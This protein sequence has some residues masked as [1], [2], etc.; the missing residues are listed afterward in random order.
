MN[1]RSVKG[2]LALAVTLAMLVSVFSGFTF[3]DSVQV[4]PIQEAGFADGKDDVDRDAEVTII[5]RLDGETAFESVKSVSGS[6]AKSEEL[7]KKQKS[8]QEVIEAALG[9]KIDVTHNYTLLYNGF[10]FDGNIW[11]IDE[12]NKLSGVS[13]YASPVY[14]LPVLPNM[15]SSTEIISAPIAW[16]LGYTGEG[17]VVAILDTGIRA[18]HEAFSVI[19]ENITLTTSALQEIMTNYGSYMHAGSDVASLYKSGKIPFGWNY[20]SNNY[21]PAHTASDHGTHVAATAAGNN[22]DDFSGVAPDAQI[23]VMQVFS[24]SGGASF[25]TI[26]AALED[27]AYLGVDSANMSLG[28][29]AGFSAYYDP[30]YSDVFDLLDEAGVNLSVSAGNGNTTADNN[31]FGGSSLAMNPD[32]GIV[33]SPSTWLPSLSIASSDNATVSNGYIEVAGEQFGYTETAANY[34][35]PLLSTIAGTHGYVL[36][37][38]GDTDDFEGLDLT[39]K[40]AVIDRG[41]INFSAKVD[42][43]AAAG[44][45]AAIICNNVEG[46]INMDL[47]ASTSNIP[48]VAVTL[49]AGNLFKASATN[50]EGTLTIGTGTF[51][52]WTSAGSISSFSGRGTTADLLIKPELTAPG[53]A[54]TS[55]IGFGTDNSYEAWSG[56]SMAA[57]HVA[58]ALAIVKSYVRELYPDATVVEVKTITDALLMSTGNILDELVRSQ[59]AGLMNLA[60]VLS[61]A[62]YFTVDDTYNNRPKLELGESE[63]GSFNF[64]FNV[65]NITDAAV[66][67][68]LDVVAMREQ[69]SATNVPGIYLTNYTAVDVSA[70]VSLSVSSVTVP[71]NGTAVV[72][73]T[74]TFDPETVGLDETVYPVG[75]FL[76]GF[77]T[78]TPNSDAA[79]LNIPF[80]GY[81]GD[82]DEPAMFDRG[83]YWH[84]ATGELNLQTNGALDAN[85]VGYRQ[86]STTTGL[87]LNLYADMPAGSY[88]ADRNAISPNGDGVYDAVNNLEFGLLRN[89]RLL[90]LT[91]GTQNLYTS[92]EHEWRKDFYYDN[93]GYY[94]SSSLTVNL[95]GTG[96]S[97]NETRNLIV[98]AYLDHDGYTLDANENGE[99]IIPVT[100]D[101][102]APTVTISGSNAVISDANYIAYY[103]VYSDEDFTNRLASEG[104]FAT[105]R[106]VDSVYAASADVVY[107]FTADYAGNEASYEVDFA[108]NTVT[109]VDGGGEPTPPPTP[110]DLIEGWYFETNPMAEGWTSVDSDG[111]GNDWAWYNDG[112]L[113]AYEGN[114]LMNSQSYINYVGPLT[115]D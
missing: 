104:V 1:Y 83:F 89:A 3:A 46:T 37:G 68:S 38:L 91:F 60:G 6:A 23:V 78:A 17:G 52:D 92:E 26:I 82:W 29:D 70:D 88:L 111:D 72:T 50:G 112:S 57:P 43:A 32:V 59:G 30:N 61:A 79:Q 40:V 110:G 98:S 74:I 48:A 95:T 39:G 12:I 103:A 41:E 19:P 94:T 11:M 5:V 75:H 9:R 80:L 56:T 86:G 47:S 63:T 99:W 20:Y 101:T 35:K 66:T 13:A 77:I 16:N 64:S 33:G 73:G 115:P 87:G 10:A 114:G 42:N 102:T 58:G 8:M 25:S 90:T 85:V 84:D 28:S 55:A 93:G 15:G 2:F 34:G 65:H 14:D 21:N 18:T 31:A 96:M 44:A 36:C 4:T 105:E 107:I 53:G 7:L 71:A 108:N 22:G 81:Y 113:T 27:C 54:I 106:D 51:I 45:I 100:L 62:G 76:E 49:A 69:A 97:E 24:P 67:Y 109:P